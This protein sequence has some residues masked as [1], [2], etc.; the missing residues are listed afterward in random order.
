MVKA[1]PT[2]IRAKMRVCNRQ[3]IHSCCQTCPH[4]ARRRWQQSD[5]K[6][7]PMRLRYRRGQGSQAMPSLSASWRGQ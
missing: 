6:G 4:G 2:V 5:S 7:G 3:H 1:E